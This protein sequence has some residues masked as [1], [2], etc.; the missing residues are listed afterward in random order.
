MKHPS[1]QATSVLVGTIVAN[2]HA[3]LLDENAVKLALES[4]EALRDA[5]VNAVNGF[6]KAPDIRPTVLPIELRSPK[7]ESLECLFE[8]AN[9]K[10]AQPRR[11]RYINQDDD[12][13]PT[14]HWIS[15][16]E[17][18]NVSDNMELVAVGFNREISENDVPGEFLRLGITPTTS[19]WYIVCVGLE[20]GGLCKNRSVVDLAQRKSIGN[21]WPKPHCLTLRH[22]AASA[23]KILFMRWTGQAFPPQTLFLGL[24]PKTK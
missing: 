9:F 18:G 1:G 6:G 14:A 13:N 21:R 7:T 24:R 22:D 11:H 20:H 16:F 12:G 17:G 8:K 2:I 19:A 5:I 15:E 10:M 3:G 23:G 4:P